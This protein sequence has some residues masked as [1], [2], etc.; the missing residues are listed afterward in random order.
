VWLAQALMFRGG[1]MTPWLGTAVVVQSFLGSLFLAYLTD[2]TT[3]WITVW[4]VG[5]LGGMVLAGRDAARRQGEPPAGA[6][7]PA[8]PR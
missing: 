6:G 3:G 8:P 5:V 2:F 7:S 4:A 1:G